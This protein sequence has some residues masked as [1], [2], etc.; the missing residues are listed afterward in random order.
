MK[1]IIMSKLLNIIDNK[2]KDNVKSCNKVDC[3]EF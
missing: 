2:I 1:F 3:R